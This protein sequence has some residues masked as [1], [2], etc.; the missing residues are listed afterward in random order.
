MTGNRFSL[1]GRIGAIG[2]PTVGL[3]GVRR[4]RLSIMPLMPSPLAVAAEQWFN[5]I[6]WNDHIEVVQAAKQARHQIEIVGTIGT[7]ERHNALSG[8]TTIEL[9]LS[10]T[11]VMRHQMAAPVGQRRQTRSLIPSFRLIGALGRVDLSTLGSVG[12]NAGAFQLAVPTKRK[13]TSGDE[14]NERFPPTLFPLRGASDTLAAAA[15]FRASNHT[16]HAD[17]FVTG[18]LEMHKHMPKHGGNP[19]SNLVLLARSI[20]RYTAE[21]RA[22]DDARSEVWYDESDA[23]NLRPDDDHVH[24]Y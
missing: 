4:A 7:Y 5:V 21:L 15:S 20:E 1:V 18:Y 13:G 11:D 2:A 22:A 19:R 10:V 12:S 16:R 17:Y 23:D 8:R 9:S 14:N 24:P 3:R 6:V